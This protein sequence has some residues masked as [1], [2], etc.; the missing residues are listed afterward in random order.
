[1]KVVIPGGSGHIGVLLAH[2]LHGAGHEASC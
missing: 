1:M 2:A